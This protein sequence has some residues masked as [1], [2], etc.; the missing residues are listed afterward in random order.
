MKRVV[1]VVL[2]AVL[3]ASIMWAS[4]AVAEPVGT[5]KAGK[6]ASVVLKGLAVKVEN[7]QGYD[8][9][10]FRSLILFLPRG[11]MMCQM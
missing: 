4:P 11:C 2:A 10:L 3:A 5:L 6:A 1:S 7:R 8:R 9:D